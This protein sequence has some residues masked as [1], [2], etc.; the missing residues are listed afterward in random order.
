VATVGKP[1][2]IEAQCVAAVERTRLGPSERR[3]TAACAGL[4]AL[5][6]NA[7]TVDLNPGL[8]QTS[9]SISPGDLEGGDITQIS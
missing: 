5:F 7:V 3:S 9:S 2:G 1:S 4:E 8:L 6:N